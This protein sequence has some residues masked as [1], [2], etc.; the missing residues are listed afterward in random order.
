MMRLGAR[1]PS[2]AFAFKL[3]LRFFGWSHGIVQ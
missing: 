1:L 2:T 3:C